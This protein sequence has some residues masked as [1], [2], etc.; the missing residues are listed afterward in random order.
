MP[1]YRFRDTARIG[2]VNVG[3]YTD[4]YGRTAH[5]AAC[6]APEC[7]WSAD[8]TSRAAAELAAE[9]HRCDPR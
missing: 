8:Y 2:Q 6:T 3:T 7:G 9:S 5:A 1:R 4:R